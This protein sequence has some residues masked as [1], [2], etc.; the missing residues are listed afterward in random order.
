MTYRQLHVIMQASARR[1]FTL[2]AFAS[3]NLLTS[4]SASNTTSSASNTTSSA[5]TG[6]GPQHHS[7]SSST[8]GTVSRCNTHKLQVT[9]LTWSKT[10]QTLAASFGR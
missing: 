6:S 2:T 9:S 7:S 3:S 5:A 8:W 10:G 4:S 1:L